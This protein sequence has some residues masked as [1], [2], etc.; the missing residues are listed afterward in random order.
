MTILFIIA[1]F[2]YMPVSLTLTFGPS[3]PSMQC[4]VIEVINDSLAEGLEQFTVELSTTSLAV[5]I[6]D[7]IF[8]IFIQENDCKSI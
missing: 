1:N 4:L 5:K 2:D 3:H 8:H 7:R 6:I